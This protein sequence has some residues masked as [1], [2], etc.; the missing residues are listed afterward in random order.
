M[1]V[2]VSFAVLE[3]GSASHLGLVLGSDM[4]AR[5]VF[6]VIGGVWAD[7]LREVTK[8]AWLR[9]TLTADAVANFAIAPYFVLAAAAAAAAAHARLGGVLGFRTVRELR[10][11][12][13]APV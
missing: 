6:V 5:M 8:R 9:V 4:A 12:P 13:D 3:L 11:L 1:P 10:R 7:R 2:A